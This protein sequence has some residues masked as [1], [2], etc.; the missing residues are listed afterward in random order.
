MPTYLRGAVFLSQCSF[1]CLGH[2][3]HVYDDDDDDDDDVSLNCVQSIQ[4][5]TSVND[6]FVDSSGDIW[7]AAMPVLYRFNQYY[8]KNPTEATAPSQVNLTVLYT[9]CLRTRGVRSFDLNQ[10]T[11]PNLY[12]GEHFD[13]GLNP[14]SQPNRTEKTKTIFLLQLNPPKIKQEA[15]EKCWAHSPQRA[16][17]RQF[18]RCR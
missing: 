9:V 11:Q 13:P 16:A 10:S 15:F 8:H 12:H 3:K 6:L 1:N 17:S 7:F 2:L 4:V 18:T 14:R 5:S